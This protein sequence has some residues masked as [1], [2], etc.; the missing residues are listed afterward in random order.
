VSHPPR[1]ALTALVTSLVTSAVV[2]TVVLL[3]VPAG[4]ADTSL[5]LGRAVTQVVT[6]PGGSDVAATPGDDVVVVVGSTAVSQVRVHTLGGDDL[7]CFVGVANDSTLDAGAGDDRVSTVGAVPVAG[8]GIRT[9]LGPGSDQ[10]VGGPATDRL[11]AAGRAEAV[12]DTADLGPGDDSVDTIALSATPVLGG[13]GRNTVL[14]G[15]E[16]ATVAVDNVTH[17]V[18][19]PGIATVS[20]GPDFQDFTFLGGEAMT[21]TGGPGDESVAVLHDGP[22][23]PRRSLVAIL[24][25]GDDSLDTFSALAGTWWGGDGDDHL[26]YRRTSGTTDPRDRPGAVVDLGGAIQ[27]PDRSDGLPDD[28]SLRGF[29]GLDLSRFRNAAVRGT[30]GTDD[31]HV[32]GCVARVDARGGADRVDVDTTCRRAGASVL[33]G[34]GGRDRLT[35]GAGPDVLRGGAG[36][37]VLRGRGGRDTALGGAGRDRCS[38]ESRTSC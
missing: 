24:G 15:G 26:S 16:A 33:S 9:D 6:G 3:P 2:A 19:S 36:D 13:A 18:T 21:M 14:V 4:A 25:A 32:S 8:R 20:F 23:G 31:I 35:A 7:V 38:A 34:G 37:D 29:E 22:G 10:L 17:T 30:S 5:C 28:V 12:G 27:R 1:L 11:T